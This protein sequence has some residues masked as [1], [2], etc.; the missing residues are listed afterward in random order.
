MRLH[1]S[2]IEKNIPIFKHTTQQKLGTL[3]EFIIED[4]YPAL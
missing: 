4:E 2:V 1:F 3:Q